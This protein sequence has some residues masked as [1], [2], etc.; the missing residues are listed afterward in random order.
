MMA[1]KTLFADEFVET[2]RYDTRKEALEAKTSWF[3]GDELRRVRRR[4]NHGTR[5]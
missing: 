3:S 1:T 5:A 2:Q 4:R